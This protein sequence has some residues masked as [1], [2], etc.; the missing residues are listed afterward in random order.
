VNSVLPRT[1]DN[2]DQGHALALWLLGLVL[3][4]KFAQIF[5]VFV[6]GPEMVSSADG[7][8]LHAFPAD[9]A[10]TVVVAFIGMGVSRLL[11][12]T[13]CALVLWRYRSAIP[14]TFGLLA[15]HDL[16][17][18]LVLGSVRQGT[19][20]GPYVNWTLLLVTLLGIALSLGRGSAQ[21]A[22]RLRG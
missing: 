13:L 9:A 17:R 15:L 6:D 14:L 11:I 1:I 10:R 16:A 2:D 19:P 3:L 18:E 5:S 22:S 20:I 21:S 8:P 12:C 7:I 4:V